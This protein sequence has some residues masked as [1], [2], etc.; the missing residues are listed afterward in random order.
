MSS[1]AFIDDCRDRLIR[2]GGT[3]LR[4]ARHGE[5]WRLPN[6]R[7]V[8]LTFNPS[9]EGPVRDAIE[10]GVRRALNG[11]PEVHA[12]PAT[13]GMR[14]S[15]ADA[16]QPLGPASWEMVAEPASPATVARG[17]SNPP[18]QETTMAKYVCEEH[19]FSTDNRF[20][21][22]AHQRRHGRPEAAAPKPQRAGI[23]KTL[24]RRAGAQMRGGLSPEQAAQRVVKRIAEDL[25]ALIALVAYVAA[26]GGGEGIERMRRERDEA[27]ATIAKLRAALRE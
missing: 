3:M 12:R 7:H 25:D 14:P 1:M 4:R 2:H 11:L 20:G 9:Y 5:L 19:R 22:A 27:R 6:G 10:A 24:G 18:E 17:D 16:L 13:H 23:G 21:W 8:N 15:E 26:K